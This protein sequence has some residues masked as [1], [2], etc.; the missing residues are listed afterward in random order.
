MVAVS[1][2]A[3]GFQ[4]GGRVVSGRI[5]RWFAIAVTD[6]VDPDTDCVIE[7][8]ISSTSKLWREIRETEE[9]PRVCCGASTSSAAALLLAFT[10]QLSFN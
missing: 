4:L 10:W 7:T 5:V 3:A 1:D 2:D 8:A 6:E 9:V